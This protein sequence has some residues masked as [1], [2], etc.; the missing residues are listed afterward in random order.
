MILIFVPL[1]IKVVILLVI[2]SF[3]VFSR[4]GQCPDFP[5]SEWQPEKDAETNQA[6]GD[7]VCLGG[8]C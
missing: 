8:E 7:W 5:P 2:L 3:T 4:E 1:G 6:G